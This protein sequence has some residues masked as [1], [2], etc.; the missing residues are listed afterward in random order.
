[1]KLTPINGV[2]TSDNNATGKHKY[3]SHQKNIAKIKT[4][5]LTKVVKLKKSWID[6]Q[7]D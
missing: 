5:M 3:P 7:N 2:G 4:R 6:V 1:M